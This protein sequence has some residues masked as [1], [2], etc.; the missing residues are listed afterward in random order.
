MTLIRPKDIPTPLPS[1]WG[2]RQVFFRQE[3]LRVL[4]WLIWLR[5]TA[6]AV[7]GLLSW[8][9]QREVPA[10][11]L[12]AVRSLLLGVGG[13]NLLLYF[14]WRRM[15]AADHLDERSVVRAAHIHTGLDLLTLFLMIGF[16]GGIDSPLLVFVFFPIVLIGLLFPPASC[17]A[18]GALVLAATA[19][20]LLT[21]SMGLLPPPV[22]ML[23][24][25]VSGGP[26]ALAS[27]A[28]FA[29]TVL[30][31]GVLV[32]TMASRLK[33]KGREL[34]RISRELDAYN[35]KLTALYDL[36]KEMGL[37]ADL[38][39]LMDTATRQ[40]AR[41][42]GVKGCSIK[43]LDEE[44]QTLRFAS[45]YGLSQDY[46][47]KGKIDIDKS[48]INRKIIEG[49]VWAIGSIDEK[50]Y[51]QYPEDVRREGIA[52]LVC[53]PLRVEKRIFGIFCVYSDESHR[54]AADDIQFF[55]LMTDLCAIAIEGL[56]SGLLKLWFM[57]KVSHQLRSPLNAVASMLKPM[58]DEYL[59]PLS[60]AQKTALDRCL[61]R[62][63][64][65]GE[66]INDLLK[67]G[68]KKSEVTEPVWY[69]VDL[70]AALRQ[71]EAFFQ[72]QALQKGVDF[73]MRALGELP[74]VRANDKL[75]DELL[76]N[77]ISNAVKYTPAGGRVEVSLKEDPH[78]GVCLDVSDTGI[79]IAPDDLPRLF[80][81][82]FRTENAKTFVEEGTGLGLAI[83]KE[84]L[85]RLGGTVR[86]E[87]QLGQGSLFSCRLPGVA[88]P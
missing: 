79:G 54:F 87:S 69:P 2:Q 7:G 45:T 41:I 62:I 15:K 20:L 5:W 1:D 78:G 83:V 22:A 17:W 25:A 3:L 67:L 80:T 35:T 53:L 10:F 32:T 63:K 24:G 18:Y 60:E 9:V 14:L 12:L 30:A 88:R 23:Q 71:M 38:Q 19:G 68:E 70:A 52:S 64:N 66:L 21:A 33:E 44:S 82:F 75:I 59:G 49:A 26:L 77:L 50:D 11:S 6:M 51:F 74:K 40:A 56:R 76:T 27:Y 37:C 34:F 31:T 43:L 29:G 47:A 28:C 86:V 42:M 8:A 73:R 85:D 57:M 55:A 36:V 16:T 13:Y 4:R 72:T 84:I 61:K 58:S 48:P 65:L 46:L 39:R 81:E